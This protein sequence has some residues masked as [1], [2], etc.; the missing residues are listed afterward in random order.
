[1]NADSLSPAAP[2]VDQPAMRAAEAADAGVP[3]EE[4]YLALADDSENRRVRRASRVLAARLSAGDDLPTAVAASARLLPRS[5]REPMASVDPRQLAPLL[6]GVARHEA[7]RDRLKRR[8]RT[9]LFY[10]VLVTGLMTA[11]IAML[12]VIVVPHFRD[13]YLEFDLELPEM[14]EA[15]LRAAD[16]LP[17]ALLGLVLLWGV[18]TALGQIPGVDR[19]VHWLRT[20]LP[21]A[22]QVGVASSHHEFAS[23]LAELLAVQSPLDEALRA[24]SRMMRDRNLARAARIAARKCESGTSLSQS[25]RESLHFDRAL[26]GLAAWGEA[27]HSL[28]EALRQAAAH[29]ETEIDRYATFIGRV[30]PP[31]LYVGVLSAML[32]SVY[33]ILMPL[34]Q[35]INSFWW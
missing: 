23:L 17:W 20:G 35:T 9:T 13:M 30:A 1:M 29:Y 32:I 6:R 5:F 21:V 28:P 26:A 19:F 2:L 16:W 11:V 7:A 4:V 10:P 27:N 24:A 34:L 25:L 18:W 33:A 12:C 8:I 31:V 3:L 15:L 14:T 22:G